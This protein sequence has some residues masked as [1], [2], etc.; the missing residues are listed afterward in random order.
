[1]EV[2]MEKKVEA[3]VEVSVG[4]EERMGAEAPLAAWDAPGT[5]RW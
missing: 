2:G 5:A 1:M 4:V 3:E